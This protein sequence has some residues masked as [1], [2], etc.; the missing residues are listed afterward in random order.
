VA[1]L[2]KALELARQLEAAGVRS[3]RGFVRQLRRTVITGMDEE[4]APANEDADDAVQLLTMHKSKGLQFPVVVLADLAGKSGD[5][6]ARLVAQEL[7]FA[8]C[9]TLGF[10]AAVVEQDKRDEAEEIRLLYVAATR[11]ERR[12]VVPV[13][14]QKGERLD[15]LRRGFGDTPI[16]SAITDIMEVAAGF[17]PAPAV[18]SKTG[19]D[20]IA[21]R[22]A[23]QKSYK[24]LVARATQSLYALSPSKLGGETEPREE[25]PTGI[26]RRQAM[27]LGILVHTA[28]ERGDAGAL[29]DKARA[30]VE[31]ALQSELMAR[32][33]RADEVYRELPFTVMTAAGLMEGKIDLLF[34]EGRRWVLVDYKTDAHVDAEK[35]RPQMAA[36]EAALKQAANIEVAETLLFFVSAGKL[37]TLR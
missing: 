12:L 7:R 33:T 13:F 3:L 16:K 4:P 9:R 2:L 24:E 11:A 22:L 10:D 31:Q 8:R 37:V 23:W 19:G 6:G 36:Y 5:S 14:A 28:L 30:M 21:R 18:K 29:P 25:E 15:L 34:R 32:V 17:T 27:D 20:P 1:N 26:E 35:Y